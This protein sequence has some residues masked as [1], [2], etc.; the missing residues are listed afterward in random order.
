M[1]YCDLDEDNP[2]FPLYQFRAGLI[3]YRLGSLNHSITLNLSNDASNKKGVVH[4]AKLHY[5]KAISLFY[6]SMDAVNY[7]TVQM[8]KCALIEY[9]AESKIIILYIWLDSYI[10]FYFIA[11]TLPQLKMNYYQECLDVLCDTEPMLQQII[12]K[13]IEL[14]DNT[15]DDV[16]CD[17][18]FKTLKSLVGLLQGR[19]QCTLRHL[20]KLCLSKP[21]IN[22]DCSKLTNVYKECYALTLKL[23]NKQNLYDVV[24]NINTVILEIKSKLNLVH[25]DS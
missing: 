13:K 7:F 11:S 23:D 15:T 18:T 16:E 20:T 12:E 9:L 8:Q 14:D 1:K 21:P 17:G 3:H 25:K 4:L 6:A 22:K 19:I 24:V 2:K 10:F 5:E